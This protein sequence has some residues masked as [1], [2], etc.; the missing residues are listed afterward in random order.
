MEGPQAFTFIPFSGQTETK[1]HASH[2]LVRS[3]AM[4]A[5]WGRKKGRSLLKQRETNPKATPTCAREVPDKQAKDS[6]IASKS[7]SFVIPIKGRRKS[8][9]RG[10]KQKVPSYSAIEQLVPTSSSPEYRA[11]TK[12]VYSECRS[13]ISRDRLGPGDNCHN[14]IAVD[15]LTPPDTPPSMGSPGS[16]GLGTLDPFGASDLPLNPMAS[17]YIDHCKSCCLTNPIPEPSS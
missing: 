8:V 11:D 1:T 15:V 7:V 10:P 13:C 2:S 3:H 12:A 5:V 16:I 9:A 17:L 4:Q 14:M 6:P